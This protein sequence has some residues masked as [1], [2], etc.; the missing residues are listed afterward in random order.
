MEIL[1]PKNPSNSLDP[2]IIP[3]KSLI[4]TLE[5]LSKIPHKIQNNIPEN[6]PNNLEN[7]YIIPWKSLIDTLEIL[8]IIPHKIQNNNL[9]N[10]ISWKQHGNPVCNASAILDY[11]SWFS[12]PVPFPSIYFHY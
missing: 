8:A 6:P 5:I 3:R 1:E 9:E 12:N 10:P 4:D 11:N 2:Y 7:L